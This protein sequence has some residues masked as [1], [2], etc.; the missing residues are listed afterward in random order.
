MGKNTSSKIRA[1]SCIS[2]LTRKHIET[3]LGQHNS[4]IRAYAYIFHGEDEAEPHFHLVFRTFDAWSI[5][6]IE[7]WFKGYTDEDGEHIN[8]LV[9]KATDLHALYEYLTHSDAQSIEDGKYQ[10]SKA[11][12]VDK[13]LFDLIPRKDAYDDAYEIIEHM[14]NGAT[15]RW[16]VRRYGKQF[17]YHFSQFH[18]VKDAIAIEDAMAENDLRR[19]REIYNAT[20]KLKPIPLDQESMD[21]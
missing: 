14:L 4:S 9:E 8:T 3:I 17:V 18:A 15:N 16:L 12:I 11:D 10:Y 20:Q 19:A 21:I 7:K 13:G 5:P 6:S 1:F 2:Y